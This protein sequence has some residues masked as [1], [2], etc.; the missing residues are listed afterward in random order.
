VLVPNPRHRSGADAPPKTFLHGQ[1]PRQ[2]FGKWASYQQK[3]SSCRSV[4]GVSG[5]LTLPRE[6]DEQYQKRNSEALKRN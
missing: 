4:L 3:A 5:A 6:E 2:T 1:D